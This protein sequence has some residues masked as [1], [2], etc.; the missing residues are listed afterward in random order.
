[1]NARN[2][3]PLWLA[4][5]GWLLLTPAAQAGVL[6]WMQEHAAGLPGASHKTEKPA[7]DAALLTLEPGENELY[8]KPSPDGRFLLTL[9]TK[10][11]H[12]WISRRYTEN[13]DPANVVT[14]DPRAADSFEWED[15]GHV[16]FLSRRA[17]GLGLWDK[18]ADGEGMVRRIAV[19]HGRFTQPVRLK[20][21]SLIAVRLTPVRARGSRTAHTHASRGDAFNNWNFP[22]FRAEIVRIAPDGSVRELSE[23]V[24]PA[25]SP[26]GRWIAFSMPVG[27][28]IHLFR[29]HPDGSELIQ[30]TSARSVDVQPAW[31]PDGKWILFTS[32]R[33]HP[34]L[35]HKGRDN[36]DVWAIQPDGRNLTRLTRDR[37][38]D[39]APRMARDGMV[40]FHSDR[41]VPKTEREAREVRSAP[42]GFHIWRIRFPASK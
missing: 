35:R 21:G 13:G 2:R 42:R 9:V 6:D 28:S 27:R 19:L 16:M 7:D 32:D 5:S 15:N 8:P 29:M 41:A 10:G 39:G 36:W 30:V 17:G 20:D 3:T 12:V 34:D 40:Y 33:A 38:R 31:S 18:I 11:K 4:A 26:D 22:G 1:M 14:E 24:N 25:L 23:G 37:A